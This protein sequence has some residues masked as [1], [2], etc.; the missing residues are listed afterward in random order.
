MDDPIMTQALVQAFNQ[1]M[2]D[3][4]V[5]NVADRIYSTRS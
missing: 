3:D 4:W 5:F 1:W 2:L